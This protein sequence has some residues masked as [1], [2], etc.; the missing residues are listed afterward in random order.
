MFLRPLFACL[1]LA[2]LVLTLPAGA[3][4]RAKVS[5]NAGWTFQKGEIEGAQ[6]PE[7]DDTKWLKVTLPHTFNAGDGADGGGDYYRGVAWYRRDLEVTA[8][9]PDKR[10]ILQFDGVSLVSEV[11]VNGQLA[12]RHEGGYS[13]FR[14]DITPYLKAGNNVIAVKADNRAW[15]HIAPLG[16]DFTIF[17]GIDRNVWLIETSNVHIDP[18]DLGGAG[19]TVTQKIEMYKATDLTITTRVRNAGTRGGSFRVHSRIFGADNKEVTSNSRNVRV[20]GAKTGTATQTLRLMQPRMWEGRRDPYLYRLVVDLY[21]GNRWLDSVTIPVGVRTLE[22][23][24][25]QGLLLNGRPYAVYGVNMHAQ[26]AGKGSALTDDDIVRD[27]DLL[28]ELGVTAVRMA[29]YPHAPKAYE[30]ADRRGI[31]VLTEVPLN[32]VISDTPLFRENLTTQ[33]KAMIRQHGDHPSIIAWGLGNEV[34]STDPAVANTLMLL[35]DVAATEDVTRKTI[36][37]HCCQGD[38]DPKT[39]QANLVGYNR[40]FGWYDGDLKTGMAAWADDFRSQFPERAM[41]ITE[42]GAGGSVNHQQALPAKVTAESGWHPEAYQLAFHEASWAAIKARPW[43]WGSFVWVAFDFASDGRNEG[44]QAGINDKGLITADRRYR[45]DAFYFY[46][47]QWS[48]WPFVHIVEGRRTERNEATTEV[49]VFTNRTAV[50]LRVNGK[51]VARSG[52]A[53]GVAVFQGV[54]LLSGGNEI[55]VEAEGGL[56]DR[57]VWNLSRPVTSVRLTAP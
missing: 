28:E 4:A 53:D 56:Y 22:F 11:Y 14:Y 41:A 55:V 23:T 44:D 29:H 48:N 31:L 37:A 47:A 20:G 52:V 45:K 2:L 36:Y 50:T 26:M 54:T 3:Q 19:V 42:Y 9:D 21:D 6:A 27:F 35:N 39:L 30:E 49:R 13:L 51:E 43:I 10:L 24:A 17:G 15:P 1:C 40:Y 18:L 38:N 16:G 7:L 5:L 25:D 34:Y 46:K 57:V 8:L 33:L 32:G 12:G